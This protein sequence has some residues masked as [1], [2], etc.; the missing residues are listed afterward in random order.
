MVVDDDVSVVG[1][2]DGDESSEAVEGA[3]VEGAEGDYLVL[4][5]DHEEVG[6]VVEALFE[7]VVPFEGVEE[8]AGGVGVVVGVPGVC[9]FVC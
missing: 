6:L 3:F 9:I 1:V 5:L 8:A 2:G 4:V 7:D